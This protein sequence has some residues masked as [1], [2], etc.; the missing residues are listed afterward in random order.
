MYV[1]WVPPLD[2]NNVEIAQTFVNPLCLDTD[3]H[4]RQCTSID[5]FSR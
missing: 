2:P 1:G 3:T 5:A 4:V